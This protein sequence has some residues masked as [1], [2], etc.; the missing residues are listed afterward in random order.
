M[1]PSHR[2]STPRSVTTPAAPTPIGAYSQAIRANGLVFVS[3]QIPLDPATGGLVAGGI[4]EQTA[5]ALRNVDA[6][7]RAAGSSLGR[8]V[9]CVVYLQSMSDFEGMNEVYGRFFAADPPARTAV[10]AA[11]LPRGALIEIEAT[12]IQ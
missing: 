7:L 8:V 6:V 4:D 9:R 2:E 10:Q 5:Q 11:G 1:D 12:A 3:G